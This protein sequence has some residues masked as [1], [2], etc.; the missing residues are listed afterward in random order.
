VIGHSEE[1]SSIEKERGEEEGKEVVGPFFG[2]E[3]C[4]G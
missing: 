2:C 4:E 1:E 3:P